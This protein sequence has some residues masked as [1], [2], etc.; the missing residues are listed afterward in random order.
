MESKL[1]ESTLFKIF[2]FCNNYKTIFYIVYTSRDP[3]RKVFKM[4][5]K[6][7]PVINV[8]FGIYW[9]L[10]LIELDG[11]DYFQSIGI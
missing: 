4:V 2:N 8:S 9:S 1:I 3:H 5:D 7:G 6:Y 10:F 11:C